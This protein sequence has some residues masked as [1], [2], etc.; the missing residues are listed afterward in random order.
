ME[1]SDKGIVLARGLFREADI[2]LRILFA[3]HGLQ[4]T[5]AFGGARSRHRF[6]GCLDVL[7]V[8]NCRAKSSKSGSYLELTEAVLARGPHL[9]RHS[10]GR[11][12]A[13]M[14]CLKFTEAVGVPEVSAGP[15]FTLLDR[16]LQGL[17]DETPYSL[18]PL[19]YRLRLAGILGY[20]PNFFTCAGCGRPLAGTAFFVVSEGCLFCVNCMANVGHSRPFVAV[21]SA[22]LDVLRNVQ[23]NY[24]DM[25][26][27][28]EP[29]PA[30]RRSIARIIDGLVQYHLGFAWNGSRFFHV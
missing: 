22:G 23:Q 8:L 25:W 29:T 1:W 20:G 12:G 13:A 9:L 24:P 2:W 14:N 7:N 3:G 26:P 5:F 11:L 28:G 15:C 21:S 4:T 27:R 18:Y 19:Y 6:V 30:D 17:E 10:P 16:V